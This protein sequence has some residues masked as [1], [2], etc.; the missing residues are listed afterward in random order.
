MA[1]Y[2]FDFTQRTGE[3]GQFPDELELVVPVAD[4]T[5]VCSIAGGFTIEAG[6][7]TSLRMFG[8]GAGVLFKDIVDTSTDVEFVFTFRHFI[9]PIARFNETN[10]DFSGYLWDGRN[11]ID[12]RVYT[13]SGSNSNRLAFTSGGFGGGTGQARVQIVGS[14]VRAK[15]FTGWGI[16][17]AEWGHEVQN[18]DWPGAGRVAMQSTDLSPSLLG[19][20]GIGTDGDPAPTEPTG[21]L[22]TTEAFALRHNPRTNKVIPV[23]SSPTVTDIGANCVRPRVSKGF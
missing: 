8:N 18:T 1:Q 6:D 16:E 22:S 2:F 13:G 23:L 7:A 9:G 11:I 14:T 17:P 19:K 4:P 10:G 20:I 12:S 5:S 15:Y 21:P 3:T